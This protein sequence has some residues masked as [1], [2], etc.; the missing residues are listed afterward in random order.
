MRIEPRRFGKAGTAAFGEAT[1]GQF[2]VVAVARVLTGGPDD[3]AAMEWAEKPGAAMPDPLTK[4]LIAKAAG[5]PYPL[6][7]VNVIGPDSYRNFPIA[8]AVNAFA[9]AILEEQ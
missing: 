1:A 4:E 5:G 3:K 7:V 2:L 9:Q 8:E 6:A